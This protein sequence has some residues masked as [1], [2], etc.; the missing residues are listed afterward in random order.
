MR[1]WQLKAGDPLAMR[2]AADVRLGRTDYADDQSWEV[3]FGTAD[4]P[5][6]SVQTRYGGRVGLARIVPMWRMDDRVVYEAQGFAELP[7]LRAFAPNY[8]RI[9]A[10]PAPMLSVAFELWV[11]ESHAVGGRLR[12]TNQ[13]NQPL[14]ISLDLFAQVARDGKSPAMKLFKLSDSGEAFSFGALG[15]ITPV[16]I[17][18]NSSGSLE[19]QTLNPRL[20]APLTI[21]P[22][23]TAS[24]RWVHAAYATVDSSVQAA[25]KWL[26]ADWDAAIGLIDSMAAHTPIIETGNADWDAALAFSAQTAL[27]AMIGSTGKLPYPSFVTARIPAH[28]SQTVNSA[29]WAGQTAQEMALI[30]PTIAILAPDLAQG[31]IR[32]AL[33]VQQTDGWIDWKPGLGGQLAHVLTAPLLASTAWAIYEHTEDQRFLSEIFGKLIAFYQRWFA[34]DMDRDGDGAPEWTTPEQS[35]YTESATFNR[36]R[37]WSSNA[38]ISKAET[39]DLLAY[40]IREVQSLLAMSAI[41]GGQDAFTKV[42]N[43]DTAKVGSLAALQAHL[44]SL[45]DETRGVYL[46]H[47]RETHRTAHGVSLWRGKGDEAFSEKAAIDPANRLVI[48]TV[49][50]NEK[51]PRVSVVIE[52]VN[53]AGVSVNETIP[54]AAFTWFYGLGSAVSDQVYARLNYV[55]FDGLSRVYN[56]E[57]DTLDLTRESLPMLSPLWAGA[58]D[59]HAR[60][61]AQSV[62]DPARYGL[63][64]GLPLAP[65]D[66]PTHYGADA[67]PNREVTMLWNMLSAEGLIERGYMSEASALIGRLLNGQVIALKRDRAFRAAYDAT[68]GEGIG[69]P[70]D[71]NGV[72]PLHLFFKLIGVRMI[73]ARRV[74]AGGTFALSAPV[75]IT[76]YGVTMTRSTD[77]TRVRFPSGYETS[78]SA[79]WQRIDDP[80]A[81]EASADVPDA[82][83]STPIVT[84]AQPATETLIPVAS[85]RD[86]TVEVPITHIDFTPNAAPAVEPK[87]EEPPPPT[88]KIPVRRPKK[89]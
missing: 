39:P 33:A 72:L 58:S 2:F 14:T 67:N 81:P 16:L 75:T 26:S 12:M 1:E 89:E 77:G 66:D 44:A 52:G 65:A 59:E 63:P 82:V 35:G 20:T 32:N 55:K 49:G 41:V 31:L 80:H 86:P 42:A 28:G 73:S 27:R 53:A 87:A 3:M 24:L 11:M 30:A 79:E 38:E 84:T 21:P 13:S 10:R 62:S 56:V 17:L 85:Q 47:D 6:L 48:R 64:V 74:W 88:F 46:P 18:E 57:I 8:A 43:S 71:L 15:T 36:F 45:W 19:T 9:T 76:H 54:A 34:R 5:A 50:G 37:R 83:P 40:L 7:M 25:H 70:D 22:N 61:L 60:R 4:E 29:G 51:A 78:V 69:D 23:A 68:T